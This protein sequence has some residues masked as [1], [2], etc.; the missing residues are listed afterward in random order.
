MFLAET[1]LPC[2]DFFENSFGGLQKSA[3]DAAA[4]RACRRFRS[5]CMPDQTALTSACKPAAS[6]VAASF[7]Q[8]RRQHLWLPNRPAP[9]HRRPGLHAAE[10]E[11]EP[12]LHRRRR[13]GRR[14]HPR[15]VRLGP[16]EHRRA[17]RRGPRSRRGHDQEARQGEAPS[18]LPEAHRAAEGHRRRARGHAGPRPCAGQH[19]GH[20]RGPACVCREA[21]GAFHRRSPQ[22]GRGRQGRRDASRRW[23]TRAMPA[24]ACASRANGSRRASSARSPRSTCGPTGPAT[25]WDTQGKAAPDRHA[26][27][28][29]GPRLGFVDRPFARCAR[30]IPTTAR[31]S[32]AAGGSSAAARSATWRCTTP[33]PP[34][35][36]STS[37]RPTGSMPRSA[38]NNNDSF[39]EWSIITYHFPARG[40]QPPVKVDLV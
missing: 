13:P 34:S 14:R 33:I 35:T 38:P 18:R 12:R 28:A 29:E 1:P 17:L 5:L 20:A 7:R 39:P 8:P 16:G 37:A 4:E 22:D 36:R 23:A 40:A 26:A 21:A 10:R 2:Q 19:H 24:K 3:A 6:H 31:A 15:H 11:A 25:F 9:R 32:G 27:G 30:I